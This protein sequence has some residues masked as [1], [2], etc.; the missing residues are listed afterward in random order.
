M[1]AQQLNL[2]TISNNI[3][4][5]NTTGFKKSKME[6]QDLLYQNASNAGADAGGGNVTPT[7][8]QMGNGVKVISASRVFTQGQLTQTSEEMDLAIEGQGFLEIQK[9][10]G[11]TAYTRDGALKRDANGQVVTNDGMPVL[12]GFQAIPT[13]ATGISVSPTG[14]VTVETPGGNTTF[15]ISLTRFANPGGLKALGGNLFQETP[16]SGG[17]EVGNPGESSFGMVRQG[18]LEMSNVNV[19]EEMVNMI[20]AQRAYEVN[21]KSI[22]TSDDMLSLVNQLKR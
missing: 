17:P 11:T 8:V 14:H 16:A 22:K 3:A 20:V 21:S 6:F 15:R 19:V 4:N 9:P 10:D 12:S 7:G 13:D 1:Q 5:V 18:F 2:N